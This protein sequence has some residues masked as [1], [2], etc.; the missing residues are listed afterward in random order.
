MLSKRSLTLIA[1]AG[2]IALV[3]LGAH[4]QQQL[5]ARPTAVAVVDL[6]A[7]FDG[8][9]ILETFK[10]DAGKLTADFQSQRDAKQKELE[11]LRFELEPLDK[12]SDEFRKQAEALQYKAYEFKLWSEFQAAKIQHEQ[13]LQLHKLYRD[14]RTVVAQIAKEQ[15]YDLVLYSEGDAEINWNQ[16]NELNAQVQLRKVLYA[17]DQ[18]NITD[19][20]IQR[21]NT[22]H[23]A[24]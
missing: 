13:G 12:S 11:K 2:A 10:A 18:V 14:T 24:G 15:G 19:Q 1:I 16:V 6:Q 20:V 7:V 23:A 3:G 5:A 8:A 17:S 9:R 4:A 22:M 21:L